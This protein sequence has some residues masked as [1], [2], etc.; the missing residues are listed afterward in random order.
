MG[1]NKL[2]IIGGGA[3]GIT[4]AITAAR[5]GMKVTILERCD[6]IGK[7]ILATGNGTCN[8]TNLNTSEAYYFL[9][10]SDKGFVSGVFEEFG[11]KDTLNF[12]SELGIEFIEK[13]DGKM[14]PRSEQSNS[15]LSVLMTELEHLN[16]EVIPGET[17]NK[18]EIDKNIRVYTDNNK[19]YCNSLIIAAGGHSSPNLGSDGSGFKLAEDLGHTIIPIF[20]SLVQLKTDYPYLKHLKGTR[21]QGKVNLLNEDKVI[22]QEEPGEV[23]F[24]DYGISGPSVLQ[25]SRRASFRYHNGLDTYVTIDLIPEIEANELEH[26]L[27]KRFNNMPYKTAE[28]IMVGLINNRLIIPIL[29]MSEI[30][31]S[32]KA[33][34]ITK[35]ERKRLIN[36]IKYTLMTVTGINSWSQSQVTG[37]GISLKEINNKT[38]ESLIA[39]GVYFC[40]EILDVDGMCGGFNLQW[41]W[42]SGYIA[43][44]NA[45]AEE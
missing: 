37:G 36:Q 40:G 35:E 19:Y 31:I 3:S 21:I 26:L 4:A 45:A 27:I 11:V 42:S 6:R 28:Q 24:T 8:L 14:Y 7:K 15:V 25:I 33:A 5:C 2:I 34:D 10:E 41:A 1:K 18:V 22:I 43:G 17:V 16:V 30:E 13:D 23:L 39:K 32:K 38:L 44:K 12:F 9:N 20:P 29:R